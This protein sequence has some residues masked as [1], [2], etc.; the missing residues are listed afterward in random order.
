MIDRRERKSVIYDIFE[1]S[2]KAIDWGVSVRKSTAMI[3]A[4]F[5][6]GTILK[7][8]DRNSSVSLIRSEI[9]HSGL[10]TVFPSFMELHAVYKNI[11]FDEK[12]TELQ[13][14]YDD[15]DYEPIE[16]KFVQSMK[17]VIPRFILLVFLL[18]VIPVSLGFFAACFIIRTQHI[19]N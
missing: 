14:G 7:F 17:W 6:N 3:R 16:Y 9:P 18:W 12:A 15:L 19:Y 11:D 10:F 2:S 1:G 8:V 13:E 4:T 5:S